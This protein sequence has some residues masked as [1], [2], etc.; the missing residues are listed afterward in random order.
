MKIGVLGTGGVGQ[1]I[2][3]KLAENGNEVVVGTRDP[4]ATMARTDAGPMGE[5]PYSVWAA[6]H[7]TVRLGDFAEA[8]A[9]GEVIFNCT[10]GFGSIPALQSCNPT[11]L[12]GKVLVDVSN[13]LDFSQGFPPTLFVASNDS[14]GEQIQRAFPDLRVV[15]SL[16]TMNANVMVN[17]AIL[18]GDHVIFVAGN[19]PDAR[20]TVETLLREQFG[21]KMV[22]DLGDIRAARGL[23]AYVLHWVNVL[24]ALGTPIFNIALVK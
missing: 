6:S 9:H 11:H 10:N 7:P 15:K 21:W 1:T 5:T 23:E 8:A 19:D 4:A 18:P 16:N 12:A 17:A 22:L 20:R 24:G 14:L 13:P 2:A 3:G